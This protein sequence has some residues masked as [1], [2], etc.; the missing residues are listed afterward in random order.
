MICVKRNALGFSKDDAIR[1]SD[2][3]I[4]EA[5][6]LIPNDYKY[7]SIDLS[8]ELSEYIENKLKIKLMKNSNVVSAR[9]VRTFDNGIPKKDLEKFK[10]LEKYKDKD[11]SY[12]IYESLEI[13]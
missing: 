7:E 9:E 8:K 13:L 5:K 1:L 11:I 2:N 6:K 12:I 10:E 4:E 3:F